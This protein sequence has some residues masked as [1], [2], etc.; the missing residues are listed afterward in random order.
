MRRRGY[1]RAPLEPRSDCAFSDGV[2]QAKRTP[3]PAESKVTGATYCVTQTQAHPFNQNF[4]SEATG[5]SRMAKPPKLSR[6]AKGFLDEANAASDP[7]RS[8]WLAFLLLLTYVVVTL[9]SVSHKD[10]ASQQ[11]GQ[12]AHHQCGHPSRRLL[13]IRAGAVAARLPVPPG[14]ARHPGAEISQVHRRHGLLRDGNGEPS[15]RRASGCIPTCSRRSLAGPKPI[16][17]PS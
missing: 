14:S 15:T 2:S 1:S 12:A 17:S 8:A 6:E 11:P 4:L 5:T 10:S 13:S 16:A 7:A 3:Q 9:A